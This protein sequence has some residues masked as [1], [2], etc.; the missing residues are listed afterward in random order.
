[1]NQ[2]L[3]QIVE[4]I[5]TFMECSHYRSINGK[6]ARL[7]PRW[8]DGAEPMLEGA[9]ELTHG[10]YENDY[11]F[12]ADALPRDL[13]GPLD[14]A[15]VGRNEDDPDGFGV[16]RYRQPSLQETRGRLRRQMPFVVDVGM[17]V[18]DGDGTGITA[19]SFLGSGDGRN[20]TNI[21][22]GQRDS[23][24]KDED[25]S[26]RIQLAMAV[27][28]T[29]QFFW[30]VKIG[31]AGGPML[32]LPTDPVGAREVFRLRDIPEG[33]QRRTA[34]RHW[35]SEHWRKRRH[36][37]AEEVKVREHLRAATT[38]TW[39]GLRCEI[40]PSDDDL[41]RDRRAREQRAADRVA[42]DDRLLL[43]CGS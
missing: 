13:P 40:R 18:I 27:A 32:R 5:I 7:K 15:F 43:T 16:S 35:V 1:M 30:S 22:S 33:R 17:A 29:R 20:F 28:F 39:S 24:F 2:S 34:I 9:M 38:F 25:M 6:L 14:V 11:I 37:P 10:S 26:R 3:D 21:T 4:T 19:R 36:D 12:F 8:F 23:G 42:G 41:A 31:Y